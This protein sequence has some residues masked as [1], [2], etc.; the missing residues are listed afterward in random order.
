[1]GDAR[2]REGKGP[3]SIY[4]WGE[5]IFLHRSIFFFHRRKD[6]KSHCGEMRLSATVVLAF[7]VVQAMGLPTPPET[8][9]LTKI[10]KPG[11]NL[12]EVGNFPY[13]D[14]AVSQVKIVPS[15]I[16]PKPV[17]T[18]EPVF[19]LDETENKPAL[20]KNEPALPQK[21]P[22]F[23]QKEPAFP[24]EGET[25]L[26]AD[27]VASEKSSVKAEST[28]SEMTQKAE[29][30]PSLFSSS[31]DSTI[32]DAPPAAKAV[33]P[34]TALVGDVPSIRAS[35]DSI[36]AAV[37]AESWET[38]QDFLEEGGDVPADQGI[39]L[40]V[41][42]SEPFE[43]DS[44]SL[45]IRVDEPEP[46]LETFASIAP[47]VPMVAASLPVSE[48]VVASPMMIAIVPDALQAPDPPMPTAEVPFVGGQY[49][50]QDEA[51]QYSFSHW[52][53]SHT[54]VEVKDMAGVVAG[55]F[56][57][58]NPEG[59]IHVRKYVAEPLKGFRV[60][61][62]DLPSDELLAVQDVPAVAQA[63]AAHAELIASM[64]SAQGEA[65]TMST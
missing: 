39:V 44:L 8:P 60:A 3:Y 55:S 64:R 58:L 54:R 4:K 31:P 51:G 32:I 25:P 18:N 36:Q 52:G 42:S 41:S 40:S 17:L 10:P 65:K 26:R 33:K 62:S 28:D 1:M 53:G 47:Q 15:K 13:S 6:S 35:V 34:E 20:S 21:E 9:A 12:K 23:P 30:E 11:I 49:R 37:P 16:S 38:R 45:A 57:Y 19:P 50:S 63:K 43:E 48:M 56:A 24:S 29:G 61:A 5:S 2:P 46:V 22:A 59:E 27:A 14:P 7:A